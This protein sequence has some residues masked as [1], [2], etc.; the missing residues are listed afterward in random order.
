MKLKVSPKAEDAY[1]VADAR[2]PG[3]LTLILGECRVKFKGRAESFL[4]YGER[5]IMVK[6]DGSVLVH[7]G[8]GCDA[9]NWQPPG[10][11]TAFVLDDG[12]LVLHAFRS[13][14][15]EKMRIRFR[16]IKLIA[17]S[18]LKDK[19]MIKLTGMESDYVD[20][21]KNDPGVIEEGLRITG[22]ERRTESGAIDLYGRDKNNTPVIL[23]V[24][25]GTAGIPA[26]YQLE[27]YVQ[28][29][30]RKNKEARV[31]GILCAPRVPHMVQNLLGERGLEYRVYSCS[32]EL[33]DDKQRTLT[34]YSR[35]GK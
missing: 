4:D 10:T 17:H 7:R 5:L 32:F 15:P 19:A 28:D 13:K 26:V 33:S 21:V 9:V 35:K 16:K 30:K 31:R 24:K 34:E 11:K 20:M 27:A 25:R 23:E 18:Q 3:S 8:E 12:Q 6:K 1:E 14:P 29:L 2:K 22:R